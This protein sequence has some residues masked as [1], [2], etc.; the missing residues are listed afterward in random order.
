MLA[1]ILVVSLLLAPAL[2]AAP[3]PATPTAALPTAA[4]P[5][6]VCTPSDAGL[7]ELSGL[8]L[9]G[10]LLLGA[11]DGGEQLRVHVLDPRT[12]A[13][14]GLLQASQDPFDVEDLAVGSDGTVWLADTG[15]NRRTRT[16][17]G[18]FSMRVADDGQV[19]AALHRLTYPDGPHDAEALLVEHGGRPVVVTKE[20]T[21][22]AGVYT[23]G[24]TANTLASPGP[25]PLRKVG[26]L[27]LP[28]TDTPGGPVPV[29]GSIVVTGGAVSPDG[30]RVAV[31]TY[32]DA[33]VFPAP[34]G[35]A[36][37]AL[38]RTSVRVPLPDEPQG[39]AIAF[40]AENTLLS[41]SES[42]GGVLPALR[43]VQV[44]RA[45]PA[46]VSTI[47]APTP[48]SSR[49]V[50][51][52]PPAST[53]PSPPSSPLKSPGTTSSQGI[54]PWQAAIIAVLAAGVL[55]WLGGLVRRRRH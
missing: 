44:A 20:L 53:T 9:R 42:A 13:T 54:A 49:T 33:Y 12:C 47:A 37:A 25:T 14:V 39:E 7:A 1:P 30:T 22:T 3:T 19:R 10:G 8:G 35:D 29:I 48:D 16:T 45:A 36:V 2:G 46:A 15:D 55:V 50:L 38:T 32:T 43:T 34:D 40:T 41:G 21:G 27:Q 23:P 31:R 51:A 24:G 17:V 18:L 28:P 52:A 4:P 26:E 5:T 6:T 11:S